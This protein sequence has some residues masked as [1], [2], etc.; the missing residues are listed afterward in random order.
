MT[1]KIKQE[2]TA[3]YYIPVYKQNLEW[4]NFILI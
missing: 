2:K 4:K 3:T 1:I